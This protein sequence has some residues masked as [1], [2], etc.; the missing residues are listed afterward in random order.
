VIAPNAVGGFSHAE[1][2]FALGFDGNN[3]SEE[4]ILVM[5]DKNLISLKGVNNLEADNEFEEFSE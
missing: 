1:F 3:V 2:C 5:S 4:D